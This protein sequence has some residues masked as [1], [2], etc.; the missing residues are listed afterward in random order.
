MTYGYAACD[1]WHI[2]V[3]LDFCYTVLSKMLCC[4][5]VLPMRG[6]H[7]QNGYNFRYQE[8]DWKANVPAARMGLGA[9]TQTV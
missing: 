8:T 7:D 3:V 2:V 6:C 4:Q 1:I 5:A 9:G